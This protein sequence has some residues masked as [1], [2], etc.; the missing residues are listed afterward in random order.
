MSR[1]M[2]PNTRKAL[3]TAAGV[4][5]A[6][7]ADKVGVVETTCHYWE[8]GARP[9]TQAHRAAY[10]ALLREWALQ[11]TSELEQAES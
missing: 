5:L 6:E 3:R 4:T 1:A 7:L 11:L 10:A 9:R 2:S 8:R